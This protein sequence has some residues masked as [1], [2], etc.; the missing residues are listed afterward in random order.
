MHSIKIM[1]KDEM[2]SLLDRFHTLEFSM[3]ALEENTGQEIQTL[4]KAVIKR[5]EKI[6]QFVEF[7]DQGQKNTKTKC[8]LISTYQTP[9]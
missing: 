3:R 4:Q 9:G 1:S 5:F 2:L 8:S 7:D 6:K